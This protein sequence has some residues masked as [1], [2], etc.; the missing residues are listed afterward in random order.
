MA[1]LLP[2]GAMAGADRPD[3]AAIT[4]DLVD[5]V[6]RN[7]EKAEPL[8]HAAHFLALQPVGEVKIAP[9][10][11]RQLTTTAAKLR[12]E[13]PQKVLVLEARGLL[14]VVEKDWETARRQFERGAASDPERRFAAD[15]LALA[16]LNSREPKAQVVERI[17]A[18]LAARPHVQ[19]EVALAILT[20]DDDRRAAIA[21]LRKAVSS[22]VDNAAARYNLAVLLAREDAT[23]LEVR[24]HL[25]RTLE[26]QPDHREALFSL[27]VAEALEGNTGGARRALAQLESSPDLDAD[28][29]TR[30]RATLA[31]L[32]AEAKPAAAK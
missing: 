2:K 18:R 29:R 9:A 13:G 24:H 21:E 15:W 32:P 22:D 5:L 30:V 14:G 20:A 4:R 10:D 23:S 11:L 8:W 12:E 6:A 7:P 25:E 17:R 1:S 3:L 27:A 31:E 16:E 28:L 19:D 26:I